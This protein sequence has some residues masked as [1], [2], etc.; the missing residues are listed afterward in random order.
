M[1]ATGVDLAALGRCVLFVHPA[2]TDS[3]YKAAY[4]SGFASFEKELA[5]V[6][7][8][9]ICVRSTGLCYCTNPHAYLTGIA[10]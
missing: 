1:L 3:A 9:N 6:L 2:A 7:V 10:S 5:Q 4:N 8:L